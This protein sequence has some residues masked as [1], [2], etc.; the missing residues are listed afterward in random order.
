MVRITLVLIAGILGA[1]HLPTISQRSATI[2][3][4]SAV[5]LFF[6]FAWYRLGVSK[7]IAGSTAFLTIF[8]LGYVLVSQRTEYL[9]PNHIIHSE[10]SI[11]AYV[12]RVVNTPE[13]REKSW[14]V[15]LEITQLKTS[16]WKKARGK[17]Q[18]YI[19]RHN[20][21]RFLHYGDVVMVR[22]APIEVQPPGNPHEFNFKKYLSYRQIHHQQFVQPSAITRLSSAEH[23]GILFYASFLREKAT[24]I[25][26][27][28]LPEPQQQA[29]AL[30]LVIGVNDGLDNDLQQAYA[31]S[32]AMHVLSV[33]GLHVA[34]L[35]G[36]ILFVLQPLR[37]TPKG[38]WL[39]EFLCIAL[40]WLY[41]FVTG[42]SPSVLRAVTMFTAIA[43]GRASGRRSNIYNTLA[44]SA[45]ILL[46]FDPYLI[47][48][49]GFQ[50]SYLAVLGIVYLQQPIYQLVELNSR[51]LD[52]VWKISTVS[53]A[54][55]LSTFALGL[56]YF[57]QFPVYF[58]FANLLVI[59]LSTAVLV[60]GIATVALHFL[61]PFGQ[62]AGTLLNWGVIA[63]NG[64]V[65][66]VEHLPFSL[67]SNIYI[68]AGQCWLLM[69][70]V[71][72]LTLLFRMRMVSFI[73]AALA[74]AVAFASLSW[75]R[76]L[77]IN[78]KQLLVVYKVPGHSAVELSDRG[79]SIFWGDTVLLANKDK[80]GFHIQ[81]ARLYY[82]IEHV[83]NR[84]LH[85][86]KGWL[87]FSWGGQKIFWVN[88]KQ[89]VWPRNIQCDILLIS[90]R[91]VS[92]SQLESIQCKQIVL[93]CTNGL[94]YEKL[95]GEK[96]ALMNINYHAVNRQG[97]FFIQ[98]EI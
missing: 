90:H 96:A 9:Q 94:K 43:I 13:W 33:S 37:K 52:W 11:Y 79:N 84:V 27:H 53:I 1:I 44:T 31:A 92:E 51:A 4:A 73:Y 22:G 14:K 39:V 56:F 72:T 21:V 58:L 83:Q 71:L 35:Y 34:I 32:G 6:V 93:D 42:L 20:E 75:H 88:K 54:A 15:V 47:M 86:T 17:V 91:A 80:M 30:A 45:L 41:A 95:F 18:L 3:L 97:A 78:R 25:L 98:Q 29:I 57:H 60:L 48:S 69:G 2:A 55:Q 49:V 70:V 59:P 87:Y 89:S 28:H 61:D 19:R 40:L 77:Q 64:S 16:V 10:D 85:Q 63:L 67:I 62:L 81:P 26:K 23:K 68:S 12:G 8:L 74:L 76:R 38:S 50:L 24:D 36:I 5:F 66:W 46:L 82:G 65:Q 7:A